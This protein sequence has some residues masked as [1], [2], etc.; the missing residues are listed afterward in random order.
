MSRFSRETEHLLKL[1][2]WFEGRAVL[3]LVELWQDELET[4]GGF[5]LSPTARQVLNEFGGLHILSE[6]AGI[7]CARSDL[8]LIPLLAKGEE[9]RFLSF[10]CLKG[11]QLFLLG[12]A[13]L[14][15]VFVAI[16]ESGKVFL[17][18]DAVHYVADSF[19]AA[20]ENLLLGK[21]TQLLEEA[22]V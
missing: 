5:N 9:D 10:S 8:N 22:A 13:I 16:D 6:G 7:A 21:G 12:E 4:L 14:G 19:D 20:L 2:G 18:M 11:K 17:I 15:H 1:S 3:H